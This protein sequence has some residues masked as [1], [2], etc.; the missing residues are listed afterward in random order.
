MYLCASS[1][2]ENR[3]RLDVA[4]GIQQLRNG[5]ASELLDY[6]NKKTKSC[7]FSDK[8][9]FSASSSTQIARLELKSKEYTACFIIYH[10][11]G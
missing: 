10:I 8:Y 2:S 1:F 4:S 7:T 11:I 5:V 3:Q 9:R 6:S